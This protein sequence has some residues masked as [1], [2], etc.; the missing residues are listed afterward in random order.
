MGTF[1]QTCTQV[2]GYFIKSYEKKN[3]ITVNISHLTDKE[4]QEEP[5]MYFDNYSFFD[6]IFF[7]PCIIALCNAQ[8]TK[9][10][11]I[12][13]TLILN[14]QMPA[15]T[16]QRGVKCQRRERKQHLSVAPI[17]LTSLTNTYIKINSHGGD[18]AH[19]LCVFTF[20][21]H[22]FQSFFTPPYS[23]GHLLFYP[24]VGFTSIST[25]TLHV[26]YGALISFGNIFFFLCA[27]SFLLCLMT[28]KQI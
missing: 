1:Y 6:M 5:K 3:S 7:P 12:I 25:N 13:Q 17:L 20:V 9:D 10:I 23:T 26:F 4:A 18:T 15:F 8:S 28:L 11:H 21:T 24:N 16:Y 2:Q 14:Q 22:L 19:A 27:K